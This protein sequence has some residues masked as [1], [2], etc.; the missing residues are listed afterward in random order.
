M[1]VDTARVLAISGGI[2]GA[3]LALGLQRVLPPGD[4]AVLVNAGDDFRHLGLFVCPDLDTV[5]YTL[6]GVA[7]TETGWGRRG[8]TW[9][10]I[11]E[12]AR[13]GGET[14]FRIGDRDLVVHVERTRRLA[15]GESLTVITEDL[16]RRFRVPSAL[17][18]MT[19]DVVSTVLDT[20][21]GALEFQDYFVRR[22]CE[23]LVRAVQY[24]GADLAA[25]NPA[26]VELL[27]SGRLECVVL[28]PSNPYLSIGPI[29]GVPGLRR[30]LETCRAP[31]VVVSPVIG[32]RAVK[33]PTV[34]LMRELGVEVSP[35][36]IARH[37]AG[38]I[39]GLVLDTADAAL[40]PTVGV[41]ALV[42]P[43]L[44][45]TLEDRE[46]LARAALAFART[47]A[48]SQRLRS[49]RA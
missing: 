13:L 8:E 48:P 32:G 29:L 16:R 44:M 23:P 21:A 46:Q 49:A 36:S 42:V 6:A 25:P 11:E 1:S 4:L 22:R 10:F 28:C 31:T 18:P 40:A 17:L 34:K 37:Y 26:V 30:A 9:N 33:G 39:D 27:A 15:A 24:R 45:H 43:T 7:N 35:R 3:K 5:M 19:D 20:E 12:L 41:A 38:L 2:G 14:W 47:L